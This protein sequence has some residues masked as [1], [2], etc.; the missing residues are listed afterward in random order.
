[1]KKL[2]L[3]YFIASGVAFIWGFFAV[4]LTAGI[5]GAVLA[6]ILSFAI[7]DVMVCGA[8]FVALQQTDYLLSE[9]IKDINGFAKLAV[10]AFKAY[11][12]K[13][14]YNAAVVTVSVDGLVYTLIPD[15]KSS[16]FRITV[17]RT[18]LGAVNP[19]KSRVT[20]FR[21]KKA[22]VSIPVIV[23]NLQK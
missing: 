20:Y 11:G 21:Y 6:F 4:D 9:G 10:A 12:Y 8:K 5:G 17:T 3:I 1:M 7:V 15:F 19:F 14:A 13:V 22:I 18:L 16:V 23:Y 2:K